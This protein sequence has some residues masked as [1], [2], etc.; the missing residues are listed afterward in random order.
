MVKENNMRKF[1]SRAIVTLVIGAMLAG[2]A[3]AVSAKELYDARHVCTDVEAG[4]LDAA[5]QDAAKQKV[6][7]YNAKDLEVVTRWGA[8]AATDEEGNY[9]VTFSKQYSQI[10]YCIPE[11]VD[12]NK[13]VSVEV[14]TNAEYF[15]MKLC[16]ERDNFASAIDVYGA[17]QLNTKDIKADAKAQL[18]EVSVIGFMNLLEGEQT[19]TVGKVRFTVEEGEIGS[20]DVDVSDKNEFTYDASKLEISAL[21]GAEKTVAENGKLNVTFPKQYNQVFFKIPDEVDMSRFISATVDTDSGELSVKLCAADASYTSGGVVYGNSTITADNL[22]GNVGKAELRVLCL[23]SLSQTELVK[24]IGNI[25][26]KL[27]PKA[28]DAVKTEFKYSMTELEQKAAWGVDV[29]E[30]DGGHKLTYKSQY[31]QMFYVIPDEVDMTRIEYVSVEVDSTEEFSVKLC[32]A[33]DDFTEAAV[34]YGSNVLRDSNLNGNV[35]KSEIKILDLMSLT[36]DTVTKTVKSVTFKLKEPS[37]V[38][39][40][41]GSFK[42][43]YKDKANNN[44]IATQR[45]SADPS[46]MVYNGRVYV[47]ATNDVYEYNADGDVKENAYGKVKTINCFSTTDF[48][49]WTDHGAIPVAGKNLEEGAPEGA[50]KWANNSWAPCAAHK[51]IDGKEK[52]F[53]YFADNGSGI[54]VLT[55][56]SPE[57]PWTDPLGKQLVS[58]QTPTCDTVEWLFD[59]AVMV[60]DD[61]SAYL[62]FGGGVP[63][64]KDEHPMTARIVKLG[65]DMISLDGEPVTIDA[66]YLFEDSGINKINGKYVYSYCTNWASGKKDG[67]G[68]AVIAYMTSDSPMGPYT[69]VGTVFPNPSNL[70]GGGNNHHSIFEFNGE[71]YIAYHTRSVDSQV[72]GKSR[73]YRSTHIDKLT[74]NEDGIINKGTPTMTGVEQLGNFNP[75][76]TIQAENIFRQYG[77]NVSGLGNTVVNASSG[78]FIGVK[79]ADFSKGLSTITVRAKAESDTKIDV[80]VG[81]ERGT[82]IGTIDVKASE[83]FQDFTGNFEGLSGTRDLYFTFN[84]N[85]VLDSWTAAEGA[86]VDVEEED[87]VEGIQYDVPNLKDV[88]TEAMGDENFIV[89]TAICLSDLKDEKEMALVKKHFNAITFGNELKPDAAFG[90]ASKCPETEK[91]TINGIEITVPKLDFSRADEMLEYVYKYNQKHP[92]SAIRIRGHVFTWHSQTPEWFFHVDYDKDKELCSKE[93]MTLRHEWYIKTMAEHYMGE[94][95][96][97]KDMFYGWDV[98]NEAI[99]DGRGTYRNENENSTWWRV[100]GSNEFIINAFRFANKYVPADVELYYNDYGDCS[101]LK[102]EGIAQLLKD[103]KAAEGTR[104]DAVGMQGHYQTAGSPSAQEFITAARKYAA[105]VGKVQITELDFGV[106]DAY[107]GTDKTKQEEYTRLAYRYKEIYDAVKQLKSEGINMSGITVWGVVDKYSWLQTSSS[108]GGGATE[109]KK[110]VPLLFDDDY[111]VKSAYWAFVDPTKLAPTIQEVT[112]TQEIDDEFTAGTELTIN[113][114]DT[115]ATIIPVWNKNTIKFLVNVKDNTIAETDAVTAYVKIGDD[116]KKVTVN[117]TDAVAI[118]DGYVAVVEVTGVEIQAFDT[119]AFDVVVTDGNMKAAFN[120]YTLSHDEKSDYFAKAELKPFAQIEKKTI[121]IGKDNSAVW[122][123]VADIPLTVRLGAEAEAA[124]KLLWDNENLYV[125]VT[126]KDAVLDATADAAHEKDSL[127]IF[128]DEN[129]NKSTSYEEDDKQYRIN[130]LNEHTFNGTNCVEENITSNVTLTEDGYVIEA[131]IKWTHEQVKSGTK[132]GLEIQINDAKGGKRAGTVSWADTTGMGWSSPAVFGTVVL[133][134]KDAKEDKPGESETETPTEKPGESETEAPTEKPGEPETEAPTEKP[135]ESETETPTEKPGEPETE[136]PTQDDKHVGSSVLDRINNG[137]KIIIEKVEAGKGSYLPN[138]FVTA[139]ID[140]GSQLILELTGAD[141]KTLVKYTFDGTRFSKAP[142][143]DFKLDVKYD[144]KSDVISKAKEQLNVPES[145]LYLCSFAHSGELNGELYVTVYTQ[146]EEGTELRLFY[147]ND[148][149]GSSEDMGQTVKAAHDGSA[150][151]RVTH[152]SSYILVKAAD[153]RNDITPGETQTETQP[154]QP[155]TD[156]P[157]KQYVAP[158]TGGNISSALYAAALVCVII[159][160]CSAA[161]VYN[162]RRRKE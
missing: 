30:A 83:D 42:Q 29:E 56:D 107:D 79:G 53:L 55:A 104:I 90:Y 37:P 140:K 28:E 108:V 24:E 36:A 61:G 44:P 154:A 58:R 45:Y 138:D 110:Q 69:Y 142:D 100:Y 43:C 6:I 139:L 3:S 128:I 109:T 115:S 12:V 66:P 8:E 96:K 99:S 118:E 91:A 101:A 34:V 160:I 85:V 135:S 51:T 113:K 88:V 72:F 70:G 134:D 130:Y 148:N 16:A 64:G 133:F 25:T 15:S 150:T 80:R 84:G 27:E 131:A 63:S 2:N 49:N 151:F 74:V 124:A 93:E 38:E 158:S 145:S 81:S 52:F 21:W 54:G 40:N 89:G 11:E 18:S 23:M 159:M 97:Y 50:A 7:E 95:S 41:D 19:K 39:V 47:Y 92:E 120:D 46:V 155:E 137:D 67:V 103:V 125:Q 94:N 144:D 68:T 22:D 65:A 4:G 75:Y 153:I 161:G 31:A 121:E 114:A 157:E 117:R 98:V 152:F 129:N 156:N 59:P 126:V 127:E 10:F 119:V 146:Y 26:F 141:G 122:N 82:V 57:G 87:T 1:M 33:D 143:N 20:G 102:S 162:G 105:I 147:Y 32:A 123:D 13:L 9:K 132:I 48:V 149:T 112:F 86:V 76:Q 116:V 62:C 35:P 60:D 78:S 71:L 77:I 111:Q 136:A 5:V 106:S 73:N 14:E 17:T